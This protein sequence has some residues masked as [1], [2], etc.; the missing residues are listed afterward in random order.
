[1]YYS[2]HRP[3]QRPAQDE[4]KVAV[5]AESLS[6]NQ[7]SQLFQDLFLATAAIS[8]AVATFLILN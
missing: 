2:S 5:Y 8:S 3:V 7:N 6:A 1:M 4:V